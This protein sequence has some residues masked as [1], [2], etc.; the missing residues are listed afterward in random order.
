LRM[1]RSQAHAPGVEP[2]AQLVR[3]A[4]DAA[5]YNQA[6][7]ARLTGLNAQHV[8]QIVN[9]TEPYGRAPTVKTQQALAKIPGLSIEDIAEAILRST[10]QPLPTLAEFGAT[11]TPTR[12]NLHAVV[13]KLP[14]AELNR[15]L[16]ILVALIR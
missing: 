6:D 12:R 10:G 16:Q 8:E 7:V 5:G 1:A 13:D 15:A 4:M 3:Q 2:L 9:R 14:E 11:M